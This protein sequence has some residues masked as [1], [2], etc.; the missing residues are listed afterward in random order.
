MG[1]EVH[2]PRAGWVS[3]NP[4]RLIHPS[5]SIPRSTKQSD[6]PL[7]QT[8]ETI[9]SEGFLH[10]GDVV[11]IDDC[12]Q[13][14]VP[15]TGFVSITGRIKE[16]IITAGGE[17]VPPVLIEEKMK[18]A[19]PALSNCMTIGDKRKFL[20]ILFCLL[21]EIDED[22]GIPSAKLTG[23]ALETSKKIGSSATTTEEA[24]DCAQWKKYFDDGMAVANG[25]ATS[26]AQKV[27]KWALLPSDFSE[28]GGELTPTL[29]LKRSVAADKY[30]D[31]IEALYA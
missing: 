5:L 16:L 22:T 31:L 8:K 18:E 20:T 14:G 17:N 15:N 1:F 30:S 12:L 10:S 21:V 23:E 2:Q 24:K 25:L 29:K 11:T 7:Q 28:P 27:G 6:Q 26:R 4:Q 9:D 13:D 19:M 3:C